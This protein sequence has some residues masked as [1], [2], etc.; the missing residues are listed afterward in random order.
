MTTIAAAGQMGDTL[1]QNVTGSLNPFNE[2]AET[3]DIVIESADAAVPA[4]TLPANVVQ[5]QDL[6]QV[7]DSPQRPY[8]LFPDGVLSVALAM[9]LLAIIMT[10]AISQRQR[11][12]KGYTAIFGIISVTFT[13]TTIVALILGR[14]WMP[15]RQFRQQVERFTGNNNRYQALTQQQAAQIE[16][17]ERENEQHQT[18]NKLQQSQIT[19][20]T[21]TTAQMQAALET[22]QAENRQLTA[23]REQLQ[24]EVGTLRD[25]ITGLTRVHEQQM[26][27]LQIINASR[28]E[29]ASLL[30]GV[31]NANSDTRAAADRLG[32]V[33]EDLHHVHRRMTSST[34]QLEQLVP[35]IQAAV[36]SPDRPV[37][38]VDQGNGPSATPPVVRQGSG[39]LVQTPGV[40][41]NAPATPVKGVQ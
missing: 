17:L 39:I 10:V 29:Q 5:L 14:D 32:A 3:S 28:A 22:T 15:S 27:G 26:Q 11:A 41:S 8:G 34:Q 23:V 35:Q 18:N 21:E 1:V 30:A 4:E 20:M 38:T 36:A 2:P 25:N 33:A 40:S 6:P 13:L 16:R 31:S 19:Q 37:R 7:A 9:S 12:P 24:G